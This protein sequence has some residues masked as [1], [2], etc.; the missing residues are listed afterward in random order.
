MDLGGTHND[1]DLNDDD[2][3]AGYMDVNDNDDDFDEN[4]YMDM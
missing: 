1:R 4:G 2:D 3:E